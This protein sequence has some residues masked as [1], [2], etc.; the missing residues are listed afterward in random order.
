MSP[1]AQLGNEW[2]VSK[3]LLDELE[4]FTCAIYGQIRFSSVDKL[5]VYKFKQKCDGKA[6][7]ASRNIDLSLLPPC[8]K[9]LVQHVKRVN[10]QVGIWKRSHAAKPDIPHP[11]GHGWAEE[12]GIMEP[13]W[14]RREELIPEQ[15]TDILIDS[16][17]STAQ[18]EPEN[19]EDEDQISDDDGD[20]GYDDDEVVGEEPDYE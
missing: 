6:T 18:A 4:E 1:L 10:Y 12:N 3:R 11:S 8:K 13:L 14:F 7:D 19:E 17:E 15:L 2:D 5:R 16:I 9:A 20:D